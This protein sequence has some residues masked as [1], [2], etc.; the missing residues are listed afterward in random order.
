MRRVSGWLDRHGLPIA[1]EAAGD[2]R[3]RA[4]F[5]HQARYVWSHCI[6]RR[7]GDWPHSGGL[8]GRG[9]T[10]EA[11]SWKEPCHQGR[12]CLEVVRRPKAMP[13]ARPPFY[14][15]PGRAACLVLSCSAK[16]RYRALGF[17]PMKCRNTGECCTHPATL[18]SR[19]VTQ[20]R[21]T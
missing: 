5:E 1:C 21:G 15:P 9:I 19:K 10:L 3:Y 18:P 7:Y 14:E 2:P 8:L 4:A 20:E 17:M 16:C 11:N 13:D 6:D 12:A